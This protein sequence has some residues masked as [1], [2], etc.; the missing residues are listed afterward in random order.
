MKYALVTGAS[1]GL[2]SACV[3][4]L[5]D[6]GWMVFS[7]DLVEPSPEVAATPGVCQ[8]VMDVTSQGSVDEAVEVIKQTTGVLDA[9]INFA[10]VQA[11]ASMIEGDIT[12]TM[13]HMIDVNLM[14]MVRVNRA[15]FD[16]LV[17]GRGRIINCSSECGYLK[18]QP[19]NG[20]YTVSKYAVEAY[21]DSLR[22][23][24]GG[25][26]V[27]VIKI[28][29]GSFKTGM[30]AKTLSSFEQLLASTHHFKKALTKMQPL[31]SRELEHANDP[32]ILSK[33][34]LK[35]AESQRP[36]SNYRV[37]NS[38]LLRLLELVPDGLIDVMYKSMMK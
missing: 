19:F 30:H 14:G 24:V 27:K 20:P 10:G 22:R 32:V 1:G 38:G 2:G 12:A 18:A 29:P 34:V 4:L 33:V 23:E 15:V 13:Q 9:V 8:L 36:N 21:T 28:Q 11:M 5:A 25:L 37:K 7:S 17:P 26:G 31:M 3:R 16:M 35:A 6:A